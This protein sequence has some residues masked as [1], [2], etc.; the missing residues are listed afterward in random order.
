MS[1]LDDIIA[2]VR[3]DLDRRMAETSIDELRERAARVPACRDAEAALRVDGVSVIAEVK[4][5][6]EQPEGR[7]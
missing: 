3:V 7:V 6:L 4:R 5:V 1:I 2:G